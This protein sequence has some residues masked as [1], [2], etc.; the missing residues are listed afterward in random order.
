MLLGDCQQC[1][2]GQERGAGD[3]KGHPCHAVLSEVAITLLKEKAMEIPVFLMQA[4][5][6]E[7]PRDI[8]RKR[9]LVHTKAIDYCGQERIQGGTR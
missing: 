7:H 9:Y 6:T 3:A 2:G 5:L 8:C 1:L 4:Y